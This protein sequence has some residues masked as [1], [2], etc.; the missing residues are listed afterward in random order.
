MLDTVHHLRLGPVGLFFGRKARRGE[1][2]A[3]V[4]SCVHMRAPWIAA[5]IG[6]VGVF[7]IGR[8]RHCE[9][10]CVHLIEFVDAGLRAIAVFAV[11]VDAHVGGVGGRRIDSRGLRPVPRMQFGGRRAGL[12]RSQ[13]RQRRRGKGEARQP[14]PPFGCEFRAVER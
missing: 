6:N 5:E 14:P 9:G 10:P 12:A 13:E 1:Y 11:R 2:G 4:I 7:G 3:A 8:L